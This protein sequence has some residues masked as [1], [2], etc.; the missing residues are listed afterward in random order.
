MAT[1]TEV[2]KVGDWVAYPGDNY[3]SYQ[4]MRRYSGNRTPLYDIESTQGDRI[5]RISL[6]GCTVIDPA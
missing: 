6:T 5:N 2:F 3:Y 4:V 1:K